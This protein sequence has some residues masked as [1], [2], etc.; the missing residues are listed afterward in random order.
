MGL[1]NY[2]ATASMEQLDLGSE[3]DNLFEDDEQ[4][5]NNEKSQDI[6][7]KFVEKYYQG[8]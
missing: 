5:K 4:Q 8:R 7:K 1:E 3:D 6:A 2:V